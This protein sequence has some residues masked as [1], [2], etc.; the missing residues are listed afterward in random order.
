MLLGI[1]MQ[2]RVLTRA[3]NKVLKGNPYF[4]NFRTTYCFL[5]HYWKQYIIVNVIKVICNMSCA[6]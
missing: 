2:I 4:R 6:K 1:E 3:S 5:M